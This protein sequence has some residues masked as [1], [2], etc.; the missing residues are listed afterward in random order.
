MFDELDRSQSPL[1]YTHADESVRV[2]WVNALKHLTH[3]DTK[4]I[5]V[6]E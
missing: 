3:C 4:F 6:L 2:A 1:R 5:L